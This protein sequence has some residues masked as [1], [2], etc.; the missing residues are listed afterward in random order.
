MDILPDRHREDLHC[1]ADEVEKIEE[2]E[3]T[4]NEEHGA[5]GDSNITI[6]IQGI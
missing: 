3:E 4:E 5:N 2:I 1:I 6:D